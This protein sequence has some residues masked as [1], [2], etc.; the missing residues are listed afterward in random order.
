MAKYRDTFNQS[1]VALARTAYIP[2]SRLALFIIYFWFGT[3]KIVGES[4][5]NPLVSELMGKTLPFVTFE[6][7][8]IAFGIYEML[9]GITFL[10]PRLER[11]ALTLFIPHVIMTT[12]PLLLL[13][14]SSWQGM[15]V[16]TLEGQYII[17]NLALIALALGILSRPKT[18][19]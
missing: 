2:F 12:L 7:F 6:Q 8:I 14:V 11:L 10:I 16:P 15:F 17:K 18:R 4:P 3:L 9:I 5:A 13:P 1:I 19:P